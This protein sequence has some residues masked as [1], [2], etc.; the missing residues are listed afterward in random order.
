[1]T[2]RKAQLIAAQLTSAFEVL[3]KND[4]VRG[5]D[6]A[7]ITVQ[8]NNLKTENDGVKTFTYHVRWHDV[9]GGARLNIKALSEEIEKLV[10]NVRISQQFCFLFVPYISLEA[11]ELGKRGT[12]RF[13]FFEVKG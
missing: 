13:N 3:M 1:M 2:T 12:Y 4:V 11:K 6:L 9:R 7:P 10:P 8:L 5:A